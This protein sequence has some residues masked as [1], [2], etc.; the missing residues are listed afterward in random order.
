MAREEEI[1][2]ELKSSIIGSIRDSLTQLDDSVSSSLKKADT[3]LYSKNT[4]GDGYAKNTQ[5][6]KLM[7]QVIDPVDAVI[8]REA[9]P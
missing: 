8:R 6:T 5:R 1:A 9:G 4:P 7:D 3:D 2:K